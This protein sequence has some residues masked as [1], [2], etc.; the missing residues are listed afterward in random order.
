MR[1]QYDAQ[2]IG[3]WSITATQSGSRSR[4]M[5]YRHREEA[6]FRGKENQVPLLGHEQGAAR[7]LCSSAPALA[8][9]LAEHQ[10]Q[11]SVSPRIFR[12]F[13]FRWVPS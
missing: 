1:R 11:L 12:D 5:M 8:L 13:R 2:K 6:D 10:I 4:A 3:M 9:V 7:G